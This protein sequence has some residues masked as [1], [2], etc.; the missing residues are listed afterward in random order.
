MRRIGRCDIISYNENRFFGGI[1]METLMAT[2]NQMAVLF[3]FIIIGF[4]ITKAKLI[5]DG[6]AGA[7]SKL[8]YWV[9]L[10]A[11]TINVFAENF[12]VEKLNVAWKLFL[13]GFALVM[14]CVFI[15]LFLSKKCSKD[16]YIQNIYTY[17]LAIANF[18]YMGNAV[19][20]AVFPDIF[21]EYMIFTLPFSIVTYVWAVNLLLPQ[22]SEKKGIL[23]A[24]KALLNPIF[25]S[26]VVGIVLG[27]TG[28][29]LPA[30]VNTVISSAAQCMSPLAMILTGIVIAGIDLKKVLKN[31]TI[32]ITSA[33][34]LLLIPALVM[35]F[36]VLVPMDKSFVICSM[37]AV[38]MPFGLNVVVFPSAYGL[39]TSVGAG[40]TVISHLASCITIPLIFYVT[41]TLLC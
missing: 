23:K 41:T 18:S 33:L 20:L 35:L 15:A 39:D 11:L 38:A 30:F 7:L 13:F 12:T 6:A 2:L 25:I 10:P 19:V 36:F 8:E 26:M 40:M 3:L 17:G 4:I 22:T 29:K 16:K 37:C 28:F 27:L 31:K 32:Y 9:I 14:V 24:L 34:R 21:L 5:N 1:V